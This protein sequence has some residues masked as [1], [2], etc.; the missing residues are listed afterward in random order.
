MSYRKGD[1][2]F[3]DPVEGIVAIPRHLVEAVVEML[4]AMVEAD[5]KIKQDVADGGSVYE[6]MQ[7]HRSS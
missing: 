7:K 5:E 6:A 1:I 2:I 3:C 4:P